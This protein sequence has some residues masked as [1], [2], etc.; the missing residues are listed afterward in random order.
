MKN[1][2]RLPR[3]VIPSRYLIRLEPDLESFTFSG[4]E[5]ISIDLSEAVS[6][7][8]LNTAEIEIVSA[9]IEGSGQKA[10]ITDIAYDTD[11]ER[12]T[13]VLPGTLAS[14][15][16]ELALE[17]KGVL[18]D[19]LVGFYRSTFTDID[20]N[21]QIIATTQFESTDA[22]RAFPC[23]DE[24]AFKAVFETTLVVPDHLMAL[25]NTSEVS[26]K[27]AGKGKVAVEFAPT[28]KMSTY[29]V[30]FIVGPFEATE[31]IDVRGTPVRVITP[32]GKLH[33]AEFALKCAQFCQEYLADYYEIPYPGDK[34]DHV[35]I[36]DFAFGAM[37]NVGCIT[38][39]ETALLL[40]ADE[41]SQTEKLRILDVVGHELA[42]QWFGN[43]VTMEWWEG[44]WLNEAFATFM[45]IKAT[46][47]MRPD[48]KRWL[49][50]AAKERPWAFGTDQLATTRPVEF[51]VNSPSEADEMF[52]SLTY[53]K[54]SSVL[55]M[56]EMFMGEEEFRQGVGDYLRRH[57]YANSVT[58]DLW[59][60]LDRA[61]QWPIGAIM[62]TWILQRG[63]PQIE[64]APE[65]GGLRIRQRR[66][67]AIPDEADQTLWQ[68]PIRVRGESNGQT[69]AH[70][71][72]LTDPETSMALE[73][74]PTFVVLNAG[75]HG[76]YR[77][78]Y[79]PDLFSRIVDRLG[80]LD[81]IER[82]S[83]AADTF[84]FVHSGQIPATTFLE[85]APAYRD[86]R[87]PEIWSAVLGGL[88]RL[89]H[90]ALADE[91]R[92]G[93]EAYVVDLLSDLSNELGWDPTADEGDLRRRLRGQVIGALG[94]LGSHVETIR[95]ANDTVAKVMAG[96]RGIDPEVVVAS[97]DIAAHHGDEE[98]YR[99]LW[100]AHD[101]APS[102]QEKERYL[103]AVASIPLATSV[104]ETIE[105]VIA[106]Q[107]RTQD[108]AWVVGTLLAGDAGDLA[109]VKVRSKW[110]LLRPTWPALTIRAILSGV[111][112]LSRP[113]TAADVKAFFSERPLPK[114]AKALAQNLELLDANV[115]MRA[116]ETDSVSAFFRGR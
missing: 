62:D 108:S 5:T 112:A 113:E 52:D 100:Q 45:E 11:L 90:H 59:E 44:I 23:W 109:W 77:A 28:M 43:L 19:K 111:S 20:G 67:M 78:L 85:L 2:H 69:F 102:P 8:V 37:E 40:D 99:Q 115:A 51:E 29:L 66:F 35:A 18:N 101:D 14:G 79:S 92:P 21:E 39:R 42:H 86:E 91:S 60:S 13:L 46:D 98:R 106:G 1:P 56:I 6:Q 36:P 17:F 89:E 63:F 104:A 81:D 31:P 80:D 7:I 93:F 61:S 71:I 94:V 22:R 105:K 116:R 83:F 84:A 3:S 72:V 25:S 58:R 110:D 88:S 54:G 87:E 68:V 82:F 10:D 103:R 12:A 26:R 41:A 34:M 53:G 65:E 48:W 57:S 97:L 114:A 47:A 9:R 107:I 74:D 95:R 64:V 30:A 33:L 55:R 15:K 38:Y 50:F 16:Y 24:P 76:Y 32:R 4:S 49:S 73:A 75:G 27:P 96:E 70:D